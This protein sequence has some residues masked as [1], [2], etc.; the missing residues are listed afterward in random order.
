MTRSL[1][2]EME[3]TDGVYFGGIGVMATCKIVALAI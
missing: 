3:I 2:S 1:S